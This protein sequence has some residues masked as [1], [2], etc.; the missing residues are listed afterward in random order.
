MSVHSTWLHT[1]DLPTVGCPSIPHCYISVSCV[2]YPELYTCFFPSTSA[3]SELL[4]SADTSYLTFRSGQRSCIS[5]A[6]ETHTFRKLKTPS[7][8]RECDSYVYFQGYDCAEVR[9]NTVLEEEVWK[10]GHC[11]VVV[12]VVVLVVVVVVVVVVTVALIL[13]IYRYLA[14]YCLQVLSTVLFT[15]T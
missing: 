6:A 8:C 15:G 5:K 2:C 3:H 11:K 4:V 9:L 10:N 13:I 12:L 14:Q 7:R 1:H